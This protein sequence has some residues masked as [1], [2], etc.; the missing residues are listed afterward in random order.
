MMN[1]A[2]QNHGCS[3]ANFKGSLTVFVVGG[4]NGNDYIDSVE[5]FNVKD[6][7]W[8][9]FSSKLPVPL[10]DLQVVPARCLKYHMYAVGGIGDWGVKTTIYG[11]NKN[12]EWEHVDDLQHARQK[13]STI[14]MQ[15][16]DIP[17]CQ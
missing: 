14:N 4:W 10:Y 13:H 9:T 17:G 15:L 3:V 11:L 7:K 1:R 12:E 2:R 8:K 16:K 6:D 5:V